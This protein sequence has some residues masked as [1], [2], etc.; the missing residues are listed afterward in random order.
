LIHL[1]EIRKQ[2]GK[3]EA[4][5]GVTLQI[6][7][8]ERVAFIGS[9]GSG[10]TTLLRA[11]VGLLQ[12]QG[13]VRIGGVDV[14]D[15]PEL[16]LRHVAYV[17]Q[18]APPLEAPVR[19]LV[20]VAMALRGL[21]EGEVEHRSARLGLDYAS[22]RHKRFRDLS[23]GMRQKILAAMALATRAPVLVCD[24]PTANLDPEARAAFFAQVDELPPA[25]LVVLCS[26]RLEEVRQLVQRVVELQDGRVLSDR[27]AQDVLAGLASAY[28]EV[29][30]VGASEVAQAWLLRCGFR[31]LGPTRFVATLTQAEKLDVIAELVGV[32]WD[33]VEDLAVR[34]V[35][36]LPHT[37]PELEASR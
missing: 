23:G 13:R 9:N 32:H 24:E 14:T 6:Q 35:D 1:H 29:R 3:I 26:H 4:L 25:T 34:D 5:R 10:K 36:E 31:R 21:H 22:I 17:P 8:G 12:V 18:I 27:R 37:L 19:D 11:L 20:R 33:V 2:F 30:L 28:V 7:A 16:A 15:R